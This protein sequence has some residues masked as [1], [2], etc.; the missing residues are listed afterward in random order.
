MDISLQIKIT[1]KQLKTQ[2]IGVRKEEDRLKVVLKKHFAQEVP[3]LGDKCFIFE[4]LKVSN[5][6]QSRNFLRF[7]LLFHCHFRVPVLVNEHILP[8][9]QSLCIDI[10]NS[11]ELSQSSMDKVNNW[12]YFVTP[13]MF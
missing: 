5:S 13:T 12:F 6:E 11:F 7:M 2:A 9:I 1:I 4:K 3:E 8:T 10:Y